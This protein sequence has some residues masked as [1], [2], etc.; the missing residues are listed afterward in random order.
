MVRGSCGLSIVAKHGPEVF[1]PHAVIDR[2]NSSSPAAGRE[3]EE[4]T[5]HAMPQWGTTCDGPA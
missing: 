5:T 4:Q 3:S 1:A 2:A